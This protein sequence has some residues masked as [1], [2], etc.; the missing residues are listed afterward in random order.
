MNFVKL[1]NCRER[2]P[3]WRNTLQCFNSTWAKIMLW[4]KLTRWLLFMAPK[5]CRTTRPLSKRSEPSL[6]T[7][8]FQNRSSTTHVVI[9]V[10]VRV[11]NSARTVTDLT[12][13]G[14]FVIQNHARTNR[15]IHA[16][17]KF[18]LSYALLQ[19]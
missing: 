14:G 3:I 8:S 4:M 1:Y 2:N 16:T 11:S 19:S 13:D 7:I 12:T 5:S 18:I 9:N 10:A 17:S 15:T 6:M